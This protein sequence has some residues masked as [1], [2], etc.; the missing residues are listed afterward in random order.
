MD[1][2]TRQ[3]IEANLF[4]AAHPSIADYDSFPWHPN[5]KHVDTWRPNS[6]QA[7]AIDLFGTL[8]TALEQERNLIL[9]KFAA[10]LGLPVG[11]RWYVDL[12]WLDERN[13]LHEDSKGRTQVDAIARSPHCVI[14][15]ECKFTEEAGS[16]SQTRAVVKKN[17]EE[18]EVRPRQCNGRYE[19]QINPRKKTKGANRC[20]LSAKGILYWDVIPKVFHRVADVDYDPCPF[21]GSNFQL[22]RNSI[23]A[24]R[25]AQD[26]R[27]APAFVALYADS[28]SFAFPKSLESG[29][30]EKF[31]ST[32]RDD[33]ITCRAVSY[34]S[35]LR[36]ALSAVPDGGPGAKWREL[37]AWIDEKIANAAG[38]RLSEVGARDAS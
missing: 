38:R 6:S 33:Q 5:A 31:R 18:E 22:M 20:A 29:D 25:L 19:L 4:F 17:G 15:F 3:R 27:L 16:C 13:R 28:P 1:E 30:F 24:W 21:S 26:D 7:L 32:L 36:S 23:L 37:S 11:G 35:F 12:E 8:K 14:L 9:D 10:E 34:Q 2:N